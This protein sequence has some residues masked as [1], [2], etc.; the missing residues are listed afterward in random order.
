[1][2]RKKKMFSLKS[3]GVR[4]HKATLA[5]RL[6]AA[7]FAMLP[8]L[9]F[10][11]EAPRS[12]VISFDRLNLVADETHDPAGLQS[13]SFSLYHKRFA[14]VHRYRHGGG[15]PSV[16][17]FFHATPT[18]RC[19]TKEISFPA[20]NRLHTGRYLLTLC[21]GDLY[22]TFVLEKNTM[23]RECASLAV[24]P[25]SGTLSL[26]IAG[27]GAA[28]N[29]KP[30]P[31]AGE[32]AN[33]IP[34]GAAGLEQTLLFDDEGWRLK[35]KSDLSNAKRDDIRERLQ[36][37]TARAANDPDQEIRLSA[38]IRA[39]YLTA[40]I[41]GDVDAVFP[42]LEAA[43]P[44]KS[45]HYA[46]E[47]FKKI[48]AKNETASTPDVEFIDLSG[49][50]DFTLIPYVAQKGDTLLA[51]ARR[52][53]CGGLDGLIR[54]NPRIAKKGYV[55]KAGETLQVPVPVSFRADQL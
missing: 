40:R 1:M 26:A 32:L 29:A 25:V 42:A 13:S 9:A 55:L 14:N 19:T 52:H 15:A 10:A 39:V 48:I 38:A 5:A 4:V 28:G 21:G 44:E 12:T 3:F 54:A 49:I 37:L 31:D 53:P 16:A 17:D 51:V 50:E 35:R 2:K 7:A 43:L 22:A 33:L 41:D 47:L 18:R 24:D 23:G 6:L 11:G 30:N 27:G 36:A 20:E 45:R 34:D 46:P 8:G